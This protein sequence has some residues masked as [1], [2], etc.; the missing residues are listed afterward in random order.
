MGEMRLRLILLR[1]VLL[2][3]CIS[4]LP[5]CAARAADQT[6]AVTV[7]DVGALLR[8]VETHQRRIDR[9]R[10][11]YTFQEIARIEDVDGNG[12]VKKV[13]TEEHEVFFVNGHPI[14]RQIMKDGK[15]LSAGEQK[16]EQD[17]VNKAV[18]KASKTAPG[19]PVNGDAISVHRLLEIIAIKNPRR[20]VYKG[21][22]TITFDFVGDPHAKT[23]GMTEDISKKLSGTVWIDEKDREVARMEAR[24][25][26]NFKIGGGLV[27]SVQKGSSFTFDQGLVNQE[28]WLPTG[29][30]VRLSA[31]ILL[32]KGIRQNIHFQ[33]ERY[34]KFH[35]D[36]QQQTGATVVQPAKP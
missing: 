8:E 19:D 20:V 13:S 36:A 23:H 7:P 10:E 30:D 28:L 6:S 17:R 31:R 29:G 25:D 1:F 2:L 11:D 32:L 22:A 18:E 26:E 24:I 3:L 14:R 5:P 33:N 9:V 15:E 27:A 21:R 12:K 4:L 34:Q 35:A 16:K